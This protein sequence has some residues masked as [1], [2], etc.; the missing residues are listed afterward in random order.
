MSAPVILLGG[1]ENTLSAVRT[2]GRLGAKVLVIGRKGDFASRSRYCHQFE[3]AGEDETLADACRRILLDEATSQ[4]AGGVVF[5]CS[6]DAIAFVAD[7]DAALRERYKLEP[8]SPQ[9][10]RS[11]LDKR[12]TLKIAKAAGVPAPKNWDVTTPEELEACARE[13]AFPVLVK[14][15]DSAAFTAIYKQKLFVAHTPEEMT[16]QSARA[17][18]RGLDMMVVEIIPG[19]DTLLSSYYTYVAPDGARLYDF[20]KKVVRRYPEN[21]GAAC[22]H[23]TED[24]PETAELAKRFFEHAGLRGMGNI[25]FKRDTRDGLLKI[26]EVNARFTAALEHAARAGAPLDVIAYA[27]I[28]GQT[29]PVIDSVREGLQMYYPLRDFKAAQA[30]KKDGRL[31]WRNWLGE[32]LA[33]KRFTP[34]FAW[35][36][37]GPVKQALGNVLGRIGRKKS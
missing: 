23:E 5:P 33:K 9:Q 32:R 16:E 21:Y 15:V 22:C 7:H 28:T 12:E 1:R 13:A 31:K 37:L 34:Y 36:D 10:R 24:L 35:D 20:T 6:D 4:W 26:I 29:P 25:E 2:F 14:P 19:P 11:F 18:S 30:L 17:L 27:A 8:A 3:A